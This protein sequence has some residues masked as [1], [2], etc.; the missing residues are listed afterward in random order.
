[1]NHYIE[2]VKQFHETFNHPNNNYKD[3]IDLNIRQLRIKLIFEELQELA[4]ASDVKE[5]FG[6]LCLEA[7]SKYKGESCLCDPNKV[8]FNIED[9]NNVNKKEELDALCDIQYVLS[10]AVLSLGY[11][12]IFDK[13]FDEVQESNMSKMCHNLEHVDRTIKDY[14]AKGV[15]S[16]YV[17]KNDGYIVLREGDDKILKNSFYKEANLEQFL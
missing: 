16:Y 17:E 12:E 9:S 10:G 15:N 1:M 4:E 13:A 2:S 11:Q 5:T 8:Q 14:K 3:D 6:K 7:I